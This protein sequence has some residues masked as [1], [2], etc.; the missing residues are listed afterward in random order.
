MPAGEAGLRM[1]R[2]LCTGGSALGEV[3]KW[4]ITY[5]APTGE[6]ENFIDA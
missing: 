2:H 6:P 3:P 5:L 1:R 4:H